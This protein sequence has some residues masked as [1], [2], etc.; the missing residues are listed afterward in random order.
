LSGQARV[1]VAAAGEVAVLELP[2]E[3]TVEEVMSRA[4]EKLA[5]EGDGWEPYCGDGTT[6]HNK[7]ERT[8][9]ELHERRICPR[10]EFELR[11]PP[12]QPAG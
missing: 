6:L 8:L 4:R 11:A 12:P 9:G 3:A 5:L 7:L 10:L 1:T 2:W